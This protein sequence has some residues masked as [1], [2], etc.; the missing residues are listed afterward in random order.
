MEVVRKTIKGENVETNPSTIDLREYK[1]IYLI[2][3]SYYGKIMSPV[4]NF[5]LRDL[6]TSSVEYDIIRFTPIK[7]RYNIETLDKMGENVAKQVQLT[8]ISYGKVK[9]QSLLIKK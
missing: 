9:N 7:Y 2:T 3:E 1:H 4:L 8:F 6:K 5:C